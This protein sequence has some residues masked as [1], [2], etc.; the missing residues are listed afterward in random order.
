MV[1]VAEQFSNLRNTLGSILGIF[2]LLRWMRTLFAKITGRPPPADATS[3]TP[4]AFASFQGLTSS[5]QTPGVPPTPSR[6]PFV[7]FLLAIFG[8]PYLMTKLIR[9]LAKSAEEQQ[10]QL[11]HY[12]PNNP[13]SEQ[14]Q[15]LDPSKLTFCRVLYDYPPSSGPTP[16]PSSEGFDLSVKKGDLVAVLSKT[17]P[18][19]NESDWWRCRAR[20]GRMGWLPG[21]WLEVVQRRPQAGLE[22]QITEKG[23]EGRANTLST[24]GGGSGESRSNSL[25]KEEEKVPVPVPV[26][27]SVGLGKEK[28]IGGGVEGFQRG[29]YYS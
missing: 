9:S 6:K 10:Q 21:V 23:E 13:Y 5:H 25:K 24:L 14:T 4:S 18:A 27:V 3:L 26:P 29:G 19:G 7:I 20:D 28:D 8:L 2:T 22:R 15:R 1:S 16:S 17:D 12:D 11:V